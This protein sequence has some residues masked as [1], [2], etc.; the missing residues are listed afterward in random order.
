LPSE[1]QLGA[2]LEALAEQIADRVLS[3]IN[4]QADEETPAQSPWLSI[5][6]TAAYL[7]WPKQRLY[8]LTA[9]GQIPHYKQEGRLLFHRRELDEWLAHFAQPASRTG[10]V[11]RIGPCVS[12]K[13]DSTGRE[14]D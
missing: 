4:E 11:Q 8:R 2:F 5:E 3:R 9:S 13:A 12:T 14:R 1:T 6:S 10:F 7:D